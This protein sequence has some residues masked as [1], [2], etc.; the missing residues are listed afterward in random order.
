LLGNSPDPSLNSACIAYPLP[1]SKR[2]KKER[3]KKEKEKKKKF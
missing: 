2:K 3:K 1:Q